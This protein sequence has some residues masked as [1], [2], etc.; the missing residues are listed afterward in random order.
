MTQGSLI[1]RTLSIVTVFITS[2]ASTAHSETENPN[3]YPSRPI[4]IVVPA[5]PGGVNDILARLIGPRMSETFGQPVIVENKPGGGTAVGASAV[6]RAT[7]DGYSMLM[8]GTATMAVIPAV[9]ANVSFVP[10]RDFIPVATV[11]TYPYVLATTPNIRIHTVK[12]LI[13][14]SHAN[15]KKSNAGGAS[16]GFQ[17]ITDLF[18]A[19]AKI[20]IQY[21][22]YK[23]ASDV[24]VDLMTGILSLSFLDVGPAMPNI[25]AEKIHPLAVTSKVRLSSL[26]HVP[27]ML[28]IGMKDMVFESWAG[29]FLPASTP[30]AIVKKL[31]N[32]ILRIVTLPEFKEKLKPLELTPSGLSSDEFS[33]IL[34]ADIAR[35]DQIV[36]SSKIR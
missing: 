21:V 28:E 7:P 4:R 5:S 18:A 10:Q 19:T 24:N 34:A 22:P 33:L 23:G 13:N 8:T 36:R 26:P 9:E 6:A 2:L 25:Q 35:W 31:Q 20:P 27:T 12:D 3:T 15:P 30:S 16:V 32:E 17:L 14:F 1:F 29:I 11:V